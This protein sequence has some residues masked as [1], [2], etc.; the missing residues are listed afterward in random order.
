MMRTLFRHLAAPALAM[1]ALIPG[2]AT[3][4][5]VCHAGAN[6]DVPQTPEGLYINFITRISGL[7]EGSVPGFDFDPYAVAST[8]PA[9]QLRFYWGALQ[10]NPDMN[11]GGVVSSGNTYALLQPGDSIGPA[12]LFSRAAFNG[13][14]TDWQAGVT[15]AY[16]GARFRN[17]ATSVMNYGWVQLSTMPPLGFPLTVLGWCYDDSGAAITIPLPPPDLIFLDSFDVAA[18]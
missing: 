1:L 9:N 18:P 5:V 6:L 7:T 10:A 14:T 15:G 4:A 11:N 8:T 3:A 17:E 12:S 16:L 13:V 2:A